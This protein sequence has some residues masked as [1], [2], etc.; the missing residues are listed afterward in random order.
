MDITE[1]KN[2]GFK[3]KVEYASQVEMLPDGRK[4]TTETP[5]GSQFVKNYEFENGWIKWK[6]V[7]ENSETEGIW[8][9]I[10]SLY[11]RDGIDDYVFESP[12][13]VDDLLVLLGEETK[14]CCQITEL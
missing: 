12:D 4:V 10:A 2:Y 8:N 9:V 6:V 5:T 7:V 13:N 11:T 1:L 3:E 14:D